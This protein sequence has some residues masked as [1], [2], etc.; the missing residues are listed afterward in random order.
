MTPEEKKELEEIIKQINENEINAWED[1]LEGTSP[2]VI[3]DDFDKGVD[4]PDVI[5]YNGWLERLLK[6]T[7]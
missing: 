1:N 2:V 7:K 6:L 5:K 3:I 4:K